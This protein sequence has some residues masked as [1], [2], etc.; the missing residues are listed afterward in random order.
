M[1]RRTAGTFRIVVGGPALRRR[2]STMIGAD[3]L[4][5]DG[6]EEFFFGGDDCFDEDL[7]R[8]GFEEGFAIGGVFQNFAEGADDGEVV[9]WIGFWGAED[10]HEAHGLVA[11]FKVDALSA[12]ADGE[13]DFL[14]VFSAGV[15]QRDLV[16]KTSRVETFAGE[17]LV[18]EAL[19]VRDVGVAVEHARDFIERRS[20][21]SAVYGERDARRIEKLRQTAGHNAV[22]RK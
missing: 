16:A 22:G 10:E 6:C 13:D 5:G 17:Q 3:G 18:V 9:A 8:L 7:R 2:R 14:D 19:E 21:F 20:A 4:R 12:A 11:V 1:R 15:R